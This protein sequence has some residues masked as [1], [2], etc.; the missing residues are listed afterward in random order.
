LYRTFFLELWDQ[1]WATGKSV[2][3]FD[4]ACCLIA[5]VAALRMRNANTDKIYV[6]PAY[7]GAEVVAGDFADGA[8]EAP[9]AEASV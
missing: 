4:L 1:P 5:M 6:A 7:A 2:V 9:A 3:V 8:D